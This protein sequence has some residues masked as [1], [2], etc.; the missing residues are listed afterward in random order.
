[1][2]LEPTREN[3]CLGTALADFSLRPKISIKGV[4]RDLPFVPKEYDWL[5][6]FGKT[7]QP[8]L[9]EPV[10]AAL[11]GPPFAPEGPPMGPRG[12]TC[13]RWRHFARHGYLDRRRLLPALNLQLGPSG[14]L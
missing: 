10:I 5:Q 3:P 13:L 11:E 12:A 6:N 7:F 2:P 8:S 1:M 14:T 9:A 4:P